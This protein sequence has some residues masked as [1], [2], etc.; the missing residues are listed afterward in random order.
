MSEQ[1]VRHEFGGETLESVFVTTGGSSRATLVCFPTVMG[2]T[3][4]ELGFARELASRGYQ[5]LV[6]DLFGRRFTPGVDRDAAFAA[7]TRLR[8]DRGALRDRLL[9]V[10]ETAKAQPGV[11]PGR[12]AAFGYCF[13]GQ[14]AL[15]LARSGVDIAGAVSFHGLFDPPGLPPQPIKAKV[16]ALHGW[17]DPMVPPEAVKALATELTQA[18]SDWQI[19][20]YGNTSHGFTNPNASSIGVPGV[21]Y[22]K[23]AAERS[24]TAL[25]NF[26]DE[27]FAG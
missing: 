3:D 10:L 20:A 12:T 7:M 9:S 6:A 24:W 18:G 2:V 8:E 14:C 23:V 17:D 19:H 25:N 5:V 22:N 13:G 16:L 21:D 4:L 26:L 15:D 27:L 1:A 11:D